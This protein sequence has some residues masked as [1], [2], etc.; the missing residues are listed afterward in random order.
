MRLPCLHGPTNQA[1]TPTEISR[2]FSL[3]DFQC[4][5]LF[6]H[7]VMKV[8][9][10]QQLLADYVKHGSESAFRELVTRYLDLVYSTALRCVD[11]DPHRA[12]DICQTVFL[13]LARLASRLPHESMLGGWLHRH[14][15]Y[16]SST[17][18]RGERRRL[19]RERQAMEMKTLDD[20]GDSG[21]GELGPVLDSAIN[22]LEE[23]DRKAILLRFYERLDLHSVG[24]ALG[25][26]EN[27]AQKRVTR[28]LAQLHS[29]LVHRGVALSL[30]ALTA[31]LGGEAVV[32]APAGLAASIVSTALA[33]AATGAGVSVTLFKLSTLAKTK[34]AFVAALAL[35]T[36]GTTLWLQHQSEERLRRDNQLLRQQLAQANQPPTV[37]EAPTSPAEPADP[38][39]VLRRAPHAGQ[40]ARP[41]SAPSE[42]LPIILNT[43]TVQTRPSAP[44][45]ALFATGG[46]RFRFYARSGSKIRIEGTSNIHDWQAEGSL[47]GGFLDVGPAFPIEPG[48][49]VRPGKLEAHAQPFVMV[50]SLK[51]VDQ[52]G[53]P[54]SDR[55]DRDL[56]ERLRAQENPKIWFDLTELTL[57]ESA[58]DKEHP[59]LFEAKGLLVVA[60]ITNQ[61]A[62]PLNV[63]PSKGHRLKVSGSLNLRMSD[64]EIDPPT[65]SLS[66]GMI[67]VA[68]EVQLSFEWML[69]PRDSTSSDTA[70]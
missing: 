42:N 40:A 51:S 16:V 25:S 5:R 15:C 37:R 2:S 32:A 39:P 43:A 4:R 62:L 70:H 67:K 68:D 7:E 24:L 10:S 45:T 60:G 3:A 22:E 8:T 59:Y 48:Q 12:E 46:Q 29:I 54:F 19:A 17:V 27:A 64:F 41:E 35:G 44:A 14:T 65:M 30:A 63:L 33:G 18:M 31:V 9:D 20:P 55:M 47:M 61:V 34:L 23:D 26:S 36:V 21:L 50:R 6:I 58:R 53:R 38:T 56:H 1:S 11:G 52:D 69:A 57:K 28:A 66:Q 49:R 13:D